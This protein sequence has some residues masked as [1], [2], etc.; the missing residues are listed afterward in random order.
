LI[1]LADNDIILKLAQC[2]LLEILPDIL[3]SSLPFFVSPTAK[4]QLL[5]KNENK[6]LKRCGN[7]ESLDRLKDFL[8]TVEVLPDIKDSSLLFELDK[9]D[10]IDDGESFLFAASI[11]V[12]NPLLITGDR[13]ALNALSNNQSKFPSVYNALKNNVVTFESSLLIAI[14]KFGIAVVKQKL[15]GSPK[16]DGMLRM[17]LGNDAS[18]LEECLLSYSIEA[19][20]FLAFKQYLP[21]KLSE[22]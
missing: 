4:Y 7:E 8:D 16:P 5:P 9:T 6:A 19:S 2:D 10:G 21:I 20:S 18:G 14:H 1:V 12:S 15:L 22:E 13:K 3:E 17:A 11:E